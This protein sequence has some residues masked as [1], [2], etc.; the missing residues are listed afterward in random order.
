MKIL[1]SAVEMTKNVMETKE[2]AIQT[3]A[4][5]TEHNKSIS[6]VSKIPETIPKNNLADELKKDFVKILRKPEVSG[7]NSNF[8]SSDYNK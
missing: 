7:K 6:N 2:Q 4:E 3:A 5:D 1:P 8:Q